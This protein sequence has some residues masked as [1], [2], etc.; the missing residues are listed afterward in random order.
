MY[1]VNAIAQSSRVVDSVKRCSPKILYKL[2]D[3]ARISSM[4]CR[5]L[6]QQIDGK[7]SCLWYVIGKT[8]LCAHMKLNV[9]KVLVFL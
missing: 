2:S 5:Y 6:S 1:F 3:I 4:K 7:T 8:F 9:D